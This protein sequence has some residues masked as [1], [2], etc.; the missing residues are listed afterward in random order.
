MTHSPAY[1]SQAEQTGATIQTESI[2]EREAKESIRRDNDIIDKYREL[3]ENERNATKQSKDLYETTITQ[4]TEQVQSLML[5]NEK[6]T[7]VKTDNKAEKFINHSQPDERDIQI[8]RYEKT[9]AE[10]KSREAD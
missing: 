5:K 6:E 4:L 9:I 2:A 10:L 3:L 1:A 8:E 7:I